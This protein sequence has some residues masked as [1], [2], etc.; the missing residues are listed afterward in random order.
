MA[1][2]A[3]PR[4]FLKSRGI[5]T[6]ACELVRDDRLYL[7]YFSACRAFLPMSLR[8]YAPSNC[9]PSEMR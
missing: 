4:R 2:V 5:A 9:T 1:D 3:I 7:H 8:R 6:P